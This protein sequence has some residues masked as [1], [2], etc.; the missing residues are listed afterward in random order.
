M[1][2][3]ISIGR[4]G[5]NTRPHALYRFFDASDVLL[6]VGIT[7]D[8]GARFKKHRGDKPWWSEVD[9][10]DIEHFETRRQAEIAERTAI[11]EEQPLHNV[12]HN[13]FVDADGRSDTRHDLA[14]ELL[15]TF[16]NAPPGSAAYN[17]AL[18]EVREEAQ[19]SGGAMESEEVE[20]LKR[21]IDIRFGELHSYRRATEDI[22]G[23]IP[24]GRLE[25]Y[26]R[27][28]IAEWNRDL[29]EEYPIATDY[30]DHSVVRRIAADL[31]WQGLGSA[32]AEEREQFLALA[33]ARIVNNL[34][35]QFVI[36]DAY[37]YYKA[38]LAG[39]LQEL[40]RTEDERRNP[41]QNEEAPYLW[42]GSKSTIRSTP[43]PR[44]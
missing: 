6:Y 35:P 12:V 16:V 10:I 19:E 26:R 32:T 28:E 37:T 5:L 40:I 33:K 43:T 17:M 3:P 11:K 7:V 38:H 1:S 21:I 42:R 15:H 41:P 22:L 34:G 8:P 20:V 14:L 18:S 36:R 23:A 25:Q 31:A 29:G 13:E 30:L 39:R 27:L 4:A 9:R 44:S 24:D 2:N